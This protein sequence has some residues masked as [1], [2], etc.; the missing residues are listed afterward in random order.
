[1]M[2]TVATSGCSSGSSGNSSG[3]GGGGRASHAIIRSFGLVEKRVA[4][5]VGVG[6]CAAATLY[7]VLPWGQ[8]RSQASARRKRGS[9]APS[10]L[11]RLQHVFARASQ[12]MLSLAVSPTSVRARE[13]LARASIDP[14]I[15]DDYKIGKLLGFGTFAVVFRV[16]PRK[17]ISWW[18]FWLPSQ[19]LADDVY[20]CALKVVDKELLRTMCGAS[21]A[22]QR[23]E[24][25]ISILKMCR[26]E[27]ILELLDVRDTFHSLSLVTQ[28]S[29]GGE[30]F[31][32]ITRL[33]HYSEATA[34]GI[35]RQIVEAVRYLHDEMEVIHRDIKPANILLMRPVQN[36]EVPHVVLCD[37]GVSKAL[38]VEGSVLN[39]VSN[40]ESTSPRLALRTTTMTG[41]QGYV[42]PEVLG[43]VPYGFKADIW[44]LG[45][46]LHVL[47]VGSQPGGDLDFFDV[48]VSPEA[49][50]L[51]TQCL[52]PDP[53]QRPTAAEIQNCPWFT[54]NVES[55]HRASV[56]QRIGDEQRAHRQIRDGKIRRAQEL[57][58]YS[59]EA[60]RSL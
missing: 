24:A 23:L 11:A 58:V 57:R 34:L 50:E 53:D 49:I 16:V 6:C 60:T 51:I 56:S 59:K 15:Y 32:S 39:E 43:S 45:V 3:S 18:K 12:G 54:S 31:E 36:G 37:F 8:D 5:G 25:E 28:R 40:A 13:L 52:S 41:T 47:L 48:K 14:K 9:S 46:L 29:F 22:R 2:K 10:L 26:H 17:E 33:H 7:L 4:I 44:S 19:F 20:S 30:L 38:R 42:A 27:H 1:M 21:Y 35:F 55:H